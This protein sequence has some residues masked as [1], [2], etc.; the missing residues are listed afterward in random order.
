MRPTELWVPIGDVARLLRGVSYDKSQA[1]SEPKPGFVPVLRA[2]NIEDELRFDDFVFVP[3]SCVSAEQFVQ[4]GDLIIA[5]SSGSRS[6]VGKSAPL[7]SVWR[8]SF[9][10]FCFAL[11]PNPDLVEPLY[12]S[13]FLQTAQYRREVS[14]LA[15]GVNIN[16][17]KREHLEQMPIPLRPL[18]EQR[19]IVE[20]IEGHFS[21]LED[22]V[23]TL[24][25]AQQNMK[26][27][28]ASELKAAVE[29]RLVPTEAELARAEG[30]SYE[31]ASVLL[32]RILAERRRRW[33]ASGKKS[34][35]QE[36]LGPNTMVL[37][38]LPEG[39]CWATLDQLAT[40]IRNGCSTVPGNDGEVPIL[41]ISA[42]RSMSVDFGDIRFLPGPLNQYEGNFV[43]PG[44]LLFTR[45]NGSPDLVGVSGLVRNLERPTVHPDKLIRVRLVSTELVDARYVELATNAGESRAHVRTRTRTTAGQA[46][47]S[48]GDLKQM[49]I[50]IPPLREQ[51]RIAEATA[52]DL[53]VSAVASD[54]AGLSERRCGRL[55]QAILKWAFEGRLTDPDPNDEPA[56]VVLARLKTE[57]NATPDT[58][59]KRTVRG[60]RRARAP[61]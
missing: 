9:G 42:V 6:V 53:S 10:A 17:L 55:R 29:G 20:V 60:N 41:R 58:T 22:A 4:P 57:S 21:R 7:R 5:A 56:A 52:G 3:S 61:A 43:E 2:T 15:A 16:N 24:K 1:S 8:G 33:E 25:R 39:W 51:V 38:D 32:E 47:I 36:P 37:P 18:P 54:L 23:A 49:P 14:R 34:K 45:Y 19:R 31:F 13:Y 35:Y 50:P 28:R 27:Y 59:K 40:V 46:G 30:R 48:G 11:R 26:R 44:D 12:L